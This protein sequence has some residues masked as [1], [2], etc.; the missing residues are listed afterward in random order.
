MDEGELLGPGPEETSCSKLR[1]RTFVLE[2][3]RYEGLIVE[4]HGSSLLG[5]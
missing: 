1:A 2:A 3:D 5:S 4:C